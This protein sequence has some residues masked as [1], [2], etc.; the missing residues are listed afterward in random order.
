MGHLEK[1]NKIQCLWNILLT[2]FYRSSLV[3]HLRSSLHKTGKKAGYVKYFFMAEFKVP[4][5]KK[6]PKTVGNVG[7]APRKKRTRRVSDLARNL[8]KKGFSER[9][10]SNSTF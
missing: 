1:A 5:P 6:S 4:E 8:L 3:L 2:F 10:G 9:N 7:K